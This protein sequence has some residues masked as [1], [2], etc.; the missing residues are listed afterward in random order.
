MARSLSLLSAK[1][2]VAPVGAGLVLGLLPGGTELTEAAQVKLRVL[3]GTRT[4]FTYAST[5][6]QLFPGSGLNYRIPWPGRPTPGTYHVIGQ[7]RPQGS[8][9]INVD[10]TIRF[11]TAKASQ[12][13]RETPPVAAERSPSGLPG[14]V[15]IALALAAALLLALC[16]TIWKLSRRPR[17][18]VA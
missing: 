7:I 3:R 10:R 9:V 12:L 17:R 6:G 1:L 11:S 18:A 2:V 14:W 8:A 15:A 4:I 5:L 16:V 13:K